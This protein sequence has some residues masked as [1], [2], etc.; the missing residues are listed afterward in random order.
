MTKIFK[1]LQQFQTRLRPLII[2]ALWVGS[3]PLGAHAELEVDRAIVTQAV[4]DHVKQAAIEQGVFNPNSDQIQVRIPHIPG[5][6][7]YFATGN[8]KDTPSLK[9]SSNLTQ[10]FTPH[11]LAQVSLTLPSGESQQVGV[12]VRISV[13]KKVWVV[14]KSIRPHEAFTS[15]NIEQKEM[16]VNQQFNDIVSGGKS[17]RKKSPRLV[18][19]PGTILKKSQLTDPIAVRSQG[20]VRIIM[21]TSA[22]VRMV[23]EGKAL[24]D[25]HVG[26]TI[27]VRNSHNKRKLYTAKVIGE[28]RVTVRL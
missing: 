19:I 22:G 3:L 6:A 13:L 1:I 24:E 16:V 17:L 2:A 14:K 21:N 8:P 10:Y 12:P 11:S 27:R 25:G 26:D 18:L 23:V 9:V 20:F 7:L 15:Q 28:N 5:Q 4:I